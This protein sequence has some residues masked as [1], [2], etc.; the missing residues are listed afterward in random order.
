MK[1]MLE[2]LELETWDV[3]LTAI[4]KDTIAHSYA[5]QTGAKNK[6]RCTVTCAADGCG[7]NIK[8]TATKKRRQSRMTSIS[9]HLCLV[10]F[11][12]RNFKTG[13]PAGIWY[14]GSLPWWPAK[15]EIIGNGSCPSWIPFISDCEKGLRSSVEEVILKI[16]HGYY[17]SHLDVNWKKKGSFL[18]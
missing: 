12:I 2:G 8:A 9:V 1:G 4:A 14:N 17:L 6:A 16:F 5:T 13:I 11:A 15:M 10:G 18:S 3:F 7:I